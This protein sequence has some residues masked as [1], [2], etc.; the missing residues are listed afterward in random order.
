MNFGE[1]PK[2]PLPWYIL[3]ETSKITFGS[4]LKEFCANK[5]NIALHV[6]CLS[7][8]Q[9]SIDNDSVFNILSVAPNLKILDMG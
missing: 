7:L 5:E 2:V 4:L 6:Y 3:N 1:C 8:R 9:T